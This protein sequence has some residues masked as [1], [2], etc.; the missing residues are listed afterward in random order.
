[1]QRLGVGETLIEKLQKSNGTMGY[2]TVA[3]AMYKIAT[4]ARYFVTL[5]KRRK[6]TIID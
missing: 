2:L 6:D 5:G 3:W 1:M 4:P